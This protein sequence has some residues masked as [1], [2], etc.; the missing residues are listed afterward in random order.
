ME[1]RRGKGEATESLIK[2]D[3]KKD[4]AKGEATVDVRNGKSLKKKNARKP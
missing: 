4:M 3:E 1:T 2:K